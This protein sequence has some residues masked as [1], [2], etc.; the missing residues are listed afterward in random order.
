MIMMEYIIIFL[1][2]DE[3]VANLPGGGTMQMFLGLGIGI[4]AIFSLF[5]LFY[6]NSFLMRRRKKKNLAS[7]VFLGHGPF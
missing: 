1:T 4:I 2:T 5:F 7:I 3:S 6:T